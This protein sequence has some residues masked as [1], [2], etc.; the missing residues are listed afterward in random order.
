V[1]TN[2]AARRSRYVLDLDETLEKAVSILRSLPEV[3]LV[4]LFGSY[5]RGKRDLLT[6]LDLIVVMDSRKTFLE[7]TSEI[8]AR[9][10]PKVDL[11]LLVY[12]PEEWDRKSR[13]GFAR[14][15][16]TNGKVLYEKGSP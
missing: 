6:D 15:A 2:L 3:R 11:D 5:A 13:W 1:N 10:R 7:R 4:L 16:F 9:L 14:L 12:T 8:Y